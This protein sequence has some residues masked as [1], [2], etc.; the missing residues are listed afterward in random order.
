MQYS[1]ISL[2]KGESNA[3][4]H[5]AAGANTAPDKHP[6]AVRRTCKA[7]LQPNQQVR[8]QRCARHPKRQMSILR[9]LIGACEKPSTM[10]VDEW[11]LGAAW[12]ARG[13]LGSLR[14]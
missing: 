3:K 10:R 7:G 1:E 4:F 5:L 11:P 8:Q 9:P 2:Q 6:R 13:A 14:H 12:S